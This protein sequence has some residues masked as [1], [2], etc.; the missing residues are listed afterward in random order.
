MKEEMKYPVTVTISYPMGG[1][2]KKG[3]TRITKQLGEEHTAIVDALLLALHDDAKAED[4]NEALI[5][6]GIS[7]GQRQGD[8][9]K[10]A[11]EKAEKKPRKSKR[12]AEVD[13]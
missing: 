7:K 6:A 12:N 2:R 4:A 11:A 3:S 10:A 8:L 5:D 13:A 1:D 9:F